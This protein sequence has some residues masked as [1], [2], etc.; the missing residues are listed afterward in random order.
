M[1]EYSTLIA[2]LADGIAHVEFN[3]PERANAFNQ[4]MWEELADVMRAVDTLPDPLRRQRCL[5]LSEGD[6]RRH[7]RG[8]WHP[9]AL[10]A[11][12]RGWDRA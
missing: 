10:A 2:T 8:S 11:P 1:N 12:Y 5:F 4:E 3:R 9:A 6:R 7:H